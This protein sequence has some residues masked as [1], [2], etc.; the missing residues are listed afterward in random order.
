MKRLILIA[1]ALSALVAAG[2]AV[3]HLKTG[4]VSQ[5]SATLS[6]PTAANVET[7]TVTCDGQ[8]IEI[9]TGRY[10]GT[11]TSTTT[12]LNG[13]VDVFV[14]STYNTTKKLGWVDGW[15]KVHAADN[16]TR[17]SFTAINVDGKLDGWL[18]GSAGHR[19]GVVFGSLAGSFS[20]TAGLTDGTLGTG[21]GANAAVLA[22]HVGCKSDK[23][24]KPSVRLF[25]RGEVDSVSATAITVKPKDGSTN[26]TCTVKSADDVKG[27]A[28]HDQVE[29]S[30]VQIA[31]VWT[32]EK[33]RERH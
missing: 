1:T 12:D 14:K 21:T 9:T 8:T 5:V 4:D 2:A 19:D 27:I 33:V 20:K 16:R 22:K 26:Q 3:A 13:A 32:L 18:R 29:M 24:T 17:A 28:Q 6:A 11:A 10:S 25:V 30:C 23:P 7:R 15:V 31:G